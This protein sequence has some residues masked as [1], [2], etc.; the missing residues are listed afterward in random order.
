MDMHHHTRH[1]VTQ[2]ETL[3]LMT[4]SSM[5]A[6]AT[7]QPSETTARA[8]FDAKL[9]HLRNAIDLLSNAALGYAWT[10]EALLPTIARMADTDVIS[11]AAAQQLLA[12]CYA[13]L[14]ECYVVAVMASPDA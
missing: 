2:M 3:L 6:L 8:S 4:R 1:L 5:D 10:V 7:Q 9:Q 13:H 11:E 12:P 14:G